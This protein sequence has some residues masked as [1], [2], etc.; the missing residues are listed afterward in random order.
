MSHDIPVW[1]LIGSLS[2]Q[3]V[4]WI[5]SICNLL[6][7]CSIM[8]LIT[9]MYKEKINKIKELLIM[10]ITRYIA[11]CICVCV[12]V[13]VCMLAVCWMVGF[14]VFKNKSAFAEIN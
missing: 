7:S 2:E 11:T 13:G 4:S 14:Y 1:H 8:L 3:G 12:S 5:V 9:Y 6:Y 10:L